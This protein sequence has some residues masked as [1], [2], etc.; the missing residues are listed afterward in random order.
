MINLY[1]IV[2]RDGQSFSPYCL[3]LH[4]ALAI[5]GLAFN[6]QP[7]GF[8]DIPVQFD[9]EWKTVPV[10]T[11]GSKQLGDSWEIAEYLDTAY[12]DAAPLFGHNGSQSLT[13]F[14]H[15]WAN[16][17]LTPL[18]FRSIVADIHSRLQSKD[19][20]YFRKT[21]EARIGM[22][23]EKSQ[24]E[25]GELIGKLNTA[26]TPARNLLAEQ[27][28]LCGDRPGYADCTLH[29]L[30]QWARTMSDYSLLESDDTLNP[31]IQRMDELG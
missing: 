21:R 17:Q 13:R 9:G 10:I 23:L 15:H 19:Q 29:S 12:P 25:R 5:K 24:A 11:D 6:S 16:T 30:F 26:L 14:V 3:R 18:I 7:L 27:S 4:S 20:D 28:Y 2:N 31:W 1:E 22:R 8:T